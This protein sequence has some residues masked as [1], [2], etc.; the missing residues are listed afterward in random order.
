ME[1]GLIPSNSTPPTGH[2]GKFP[3]QLMFGG[4][5]SIG[6]LWER[7]MRQ[8]LW[9]QGTPALIGPSHRPPSPSCSVLQGTA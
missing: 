4:D 6:T 3:E 2:H 7:R 1:E 9:L 8:L 5:R